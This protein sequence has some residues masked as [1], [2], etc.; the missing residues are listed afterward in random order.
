MLVAI[1]YP[2]FDGGIEQILQVY[3]GLTGRADPVNGVANGKVEEDTS[4]SP[5]SPSAGSVSDEP[6][7]KEMKTED[8]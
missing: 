1:F 5:S 3:R 7:A 6:Q 4:T 8:L 2:I